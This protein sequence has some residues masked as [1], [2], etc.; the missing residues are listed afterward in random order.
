MYIYILKCNAIMQKMT[1]QNEHILPVKALP[2]VS[3]FD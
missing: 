1:V 2:A 3:R